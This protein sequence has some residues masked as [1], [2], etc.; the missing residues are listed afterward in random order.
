MYVT[1]DDD[2]T[3]AVARAQ[4]LPRN[5]SYDWI[6]VANDNHS[7]SERRSLA[8]ETTEAVDRGWYWHAA[9]Q[10]S[11]IATEASECST[12][13]ISPSCGTWP[14]LATLSRGP[15]GE[16]VMS[17]TSI[18]RAE[19]TVLSVAVKLS[20][21]NHQV[22]AISAASAHHVGGGFSSGG[23]HALEEAMCV[24]STLYRCLRH[25]WRQTGVPEGGAY[26]P[27]DGV[28]LSPRVEVFREGTAHGYAMLPQPVELNCVV[29]VAMP[30]L[31]TRV[32]DAPLEKPASPDAYRTSIA[33]RWRAVLHGATSSGATDVVC[34]DA[35]CGVYGNEPAIVGW[36]LG[37]V[38]RTEYWGQINT[39]WLVGSNEF[40]TAVEAGV[41]SA[42]KSPFHSASRENSNFVMLSA[43]KGKLLERM[44]MI[45]AAKGA[46]SRSGA[47][48]PTAKSVDAAKSADGWGPPESFRKLLRAAINQEADSAEFASVSERSSHQGSASADMANPTTGL[49][50]KAEAPPLTP[51]QSVK[52]YNPFSPLMKRS[53]P[54]WGKGASM[55]T[56]AS[57]SSQASS[58]GDPAS[59]LEDAGAAPPDPQMETETSTSAALTDALLKRHLEALLMPDCTTPEEHEEGSPLIPSL[60]I[61]PGRLMHP[62]ALTVFGHLDW[63]GVVTTLHETVILK[64]NAAGL[65]ADFDR[66]S[67]CSDAVVVRM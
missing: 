26:I 7:R 16:E 43:L 48:T 38:L 20:G 58:D 44:P 46:G 41:S 50:S 25:A 13:L 19:G 29:S 22:A 28:V 63:D 15:A 3:T 65:R 60:C 17:H 18:E 27:P 14:T 56:T 2:A 6:R 23:R 11:L 10:V 55:S 54:P 9:N 45:G 34:P 33:A 1:D 47:S 36:V 5:G 35:G 31:S 24:Q 21:E 8:K 67:L 4:P 32:R 37:E 59:R 12:T 51:S 40:C 49:E 53:R 52:S 30:N 62:N 64:S 61:N 42:S 66:L 39:L 57:V